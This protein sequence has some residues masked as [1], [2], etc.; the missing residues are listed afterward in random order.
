MP[1]MEIWGKYEHLYKS[2]LQWHKK[3]GVY[4]NKQVPLW[5][6]ES[7]RERLKRANIRLYIIAGLLAIAT[8][9]T[10]IFWYAVTH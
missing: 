6:A 10:N 4:M 5:V 3:G 8:V 7:D 2:L 1:K 9:G